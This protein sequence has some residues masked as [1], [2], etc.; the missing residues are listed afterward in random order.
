M[1]KFWRR[2]TSVA[3]VAVAATL[4]ALSLKLPLWQM[5]MEAPQYKDDEALEVVV[6]PGEMRGD[7]TEITVLNQYIGVHVPETLPQFAWLPEALLA[8]AVLGFI[9][10]IFPT[11]LRKWGLIFIPASLC[12][13]LTFAAAQ[14]KQQMHDIGHKRDEKTT[15]ARVKD[16]TPPLYGKV[17][18]FQFETESKLGL[19]AFLIGAA[20]LLQ[21]S[22]AWVNRRCE[23]S[24]CTE[25][26][27]ARKRAEIS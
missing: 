3:I 16:F 27:P 19:G 10:G 21:F 13:A 4:L 12:V 14:A 25:S 11:Q 5:R 22:G 7:L 2:I 20:I 17:K 26:K 1:N 9:A 6:F 15:L 18:I 8:T 24:N 23:Q